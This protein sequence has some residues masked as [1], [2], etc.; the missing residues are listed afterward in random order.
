MTGETTAEA[1]TAHAKDIA[2]VERRF[3]IEYIRDLRIKV[4]ARGRVFYLDMLTAIMHHIKGFSSIDLSA[5]SENTT[6]ALTATLSN[7][8]TTPEALSTWRIWQLLVVVVKGGD[9]LTTRGHC[10][11]TAHQ[12]HPSF[13]RKMSRSGV[14][15]SDAELDLTH[16]MNAAIAMQMLFRSKR[17][18]R[19]FQ[20]E[21]IAAGKWTPVLDHFF[22]VTLAQVKSKGT[23][24]YA[25]T[26]PQA[27][28]EAANRP[29]IAIGLRTGPA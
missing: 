9:L 23:I 25:P 16:E 1:D 17:Q 15:V 21:T 10:G 14:H 4:D 24:S 27:Y 22:N 12:V 18:R 28:E 5:I 20:E 13:K 2:T 7:M 11:A 26:K 19:Q 8:V 6:H 3:I 29:W